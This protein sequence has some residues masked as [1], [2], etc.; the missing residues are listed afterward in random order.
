M[1][2]PAAADPPP[3]DGDSTSRIYAG[4]ILEVF[5]SKFVIGQLVFNVLA[6]FL[7]PL[8]T[9]YL[10]FG[11]FSEGPYH[12]SSGPLVGVVVGSLVGS[13]ILIFA[14]MPI[15]L[16]E[17]IECGWFPIIPKRNLM[18]ELQRVWWLPPSMIRLFEWRWS[19]KRN[20]AIGM[21]LGIFYVPV[22]FLLARYAFG[23]TLSTWTLIWFNVIYEVALAIP[24]LL[25]G[26][27]GYALEDNLEPILKR[28]SCDPNCAAR[29]FFR[30]GTSIRMT[31]WPY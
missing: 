9:F 31:L 29:L 14:L 28:L 19:T 16:P 22:A 26:L 11:H 15:G 21:L 23:P 27:I 30:A 10:L 8:G 7:G 18:E 12:W 17:A 25:L 6:S 2:V 24:V 4:T 5:K 1:S 3:D 13:P 20:L